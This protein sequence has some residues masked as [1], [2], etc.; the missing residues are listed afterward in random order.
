V[1]LPRLVE[2]APRVY[3][4]P[5]AWRALAGEKGVLLGAK[6]PQWIDV[7]EFAARP[8]ARWKALVELRF[9]GCLPWEVVGVSLS[10]PEFRKLGDRLLREL[11][12]GDV[13]LTEEGPSVHLG[14]AWTQAKLAPGSSRKPRY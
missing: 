1:K 14:D 10:A 11:V 4:G 3:V 5:D 6:R 7:L 8:A 2:T 12:P 9:T 13:L